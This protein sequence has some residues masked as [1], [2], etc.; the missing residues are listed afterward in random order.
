MAENIKITA[1]DH[2]SKTSEN[3][4]SQINAGNVTYDIATHHS[5]IFK[6]G[7]GDTVGTEWNGLSDIEVVIPNITDIVKTPIEFAGT[8]ADGTITWKNGH[9]EAKVGNLVFITNDCEFEGIACEAG[10]MAIFDGENWN[11]VSGENQVSI[12]GTMDD[13]NK[14]TVAIGSAKDVLT[15]EGK[16]LALTLDYAEINGH[17]SKTY[18]AAEGVDVTFTNATVADAYVKLSKVAGETK[19]IGAD[20]ELDKASKLSDGTVALE[21]ASGLV[22]GV[23]FGVFDAGAMPE[24]V[25]NSDDRKFDVTGGSLTAVDGEDFVKSVSLGKVAFATAQ[26]GDEGAISVLTNIT[27]GVGAEFVNGVHATL[28]GETANITIAGYDTPES[29]DVKFVEGFADASLKPVTSISD[30]NFELIEGSDLVT[31]IS[32]G[33]SDVVT[34]VSY[35]VDNET[36]VLNT[37]TVTD[38]VLSF[39]SVNVASGVS[40]TTTTKSLTKTG[41]KYT[42]PVATTTDFVT[43]GFKHVDAVNYTFNTANETTYSPVTEMY[44]LNTPDLAIEKGAYQLSNTGMQATVPADTFAV[45]MTSGTLPS[46]TEG[47]VSTT[48]VTGTVNTALDYTKVSV[49]TLASDVNDIELP[50]YTLT[51]ADAAGDNTVLVGAAGDLG[52]TGNV[53]LTGYLTDVSI[54]ETKPAQ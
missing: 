43:S 41:F 31:G 37:A 20:I 6:D 54:V 8:V 42:A 48:T 21:N 16:T 14:V 44:K 53:D 28:E 25:K 40:V 23:T 17:V 9:T 52:L 39:G 5:I 35:E 29:G 36:S 12:V 45:S 1:N 27:A 3:W 22:N 32:D 13:N 30:G 47:S 7:K 51:S 34:A 26:A 49:H 33:T 50:A 4:I 19:T 10:D 11:V 38:H 18:G 24:I 15:V 2:V 46:L